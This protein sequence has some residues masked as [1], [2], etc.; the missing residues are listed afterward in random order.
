[1]RMTSAFFHLYLVAQT[2]TTDTA[3][4][5]VEQHATL[6]YFVVPLIASIIGGLVAT[7]FAYHTL[8]LTQKHDLRMAALGERLKAHQQA[9]SLWDRLVA[10]IHEPN[11]EI[12]L[13]CYNWW[14]DNCL[15]LAEPARSA[16][17]ASINDVSMYREV[18]MNTP[19][20]G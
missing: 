20:N 13:E 19:K 12:A 15:Y 5:A 16:F 3:E 4:K 7:V 11:T 14:R 17:R 1:M 9:Y 18:Y 8:R 6:L 10:S 2:V